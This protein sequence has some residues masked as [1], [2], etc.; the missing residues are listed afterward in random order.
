MTEN[1]IEAGKIKAT[2]YRLHFLLTEPQ[3][4][5]IRKESILQFKICFKAIFSLLANYLSAEFNITTR[6][7]LQVLEASFEKKMFTEDMTFS[8]KEMEKD[9]ET[10]DSLNSDDIYIKIK[11]LHARHLQLI[12]DMIARMGQDPEE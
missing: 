2:L 4:D 9:F 8:L 10:I 3:T 11:E 7:N 6:S 5:E 12:F 1:I